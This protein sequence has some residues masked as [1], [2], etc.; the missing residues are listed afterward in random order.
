MEQMSRPGSATLTGIESLLET[1]QASVIPTHATVQE[2]ICETALNSIYLFQAFINDVHRKIFKI[3]LTAGSEHAT[4]N[5]FPGM[6]F[7]L[8]AE[9]WKKQW[10]KAVDREAN[11]DVLAM[12]AL[13]VR[14]Y[15]VLCLPRKTGRNGP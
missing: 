4:C 3:I 1:W 7:L 15:E 10:F 9:V 8:S 13:Q 2:C 12:S 5:V 11:S 6:C 14:D